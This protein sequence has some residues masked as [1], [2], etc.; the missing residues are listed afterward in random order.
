M[1]KGFLWYSF[2][3]FHVGDHH[4]HLMLKNSK[5]EIRRCRQVGKRY[6]VGSVKDLEKDIFYCVIRSDGTF[7]IRHMSTSSLDSKA[8]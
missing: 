3:R 8:G 4:C 2:F 5:C 7:L 1:L 6:A